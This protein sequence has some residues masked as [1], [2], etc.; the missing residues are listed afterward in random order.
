MLRTPLCE[1]LG[2]ETPV[3]QA[4]IAPFT[5]PEL[6]AAVC[7]AGGLGSVTTAM[8]PLEAIQQQIERTRGLTDR[9][10]AINFTLATMDHE[11]FE[12]ALAARPA[13]I[14]LALGDPGELVER[15]HDAGILVMH[16]VHTARQAREAVARG[17]DV[18]IAQGTEAGGFTGSVSAMALIP[19]VVDAAGTVPVVAA[20][21][22][23]DGR[24][25][26][27]ALV[28]GAQGVN[29]GTRCLAAAEAACSESWK[30]AL[31]AAESED[32]VKVQEWYDVFPRPTGAL[33][34]TCPRS[35]R[36][37]FLDHWQRHPDAARREADRV[38]NE[39]LGGLRRGTMHEFIPFSG[40]TAGMIHEVLPAAEIVRRLVAEAERALTRPVAAWPTGSDV[41]CRSE[42]QAQGR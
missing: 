29:I 22:I 5:S 15:I 38:Q 23:A 25:L 33:Y 27:A 11:A 13:V 6:V 39:I 10:F 26:A 1:L 8:Q 21:G 30:A 7:N 35:L 37:P 19:Q 9:P 32:A 3:I 41:L 12:L 14:S 20:G 34:D 24:G 18:I 36:T 42:S 40:Q 16:Q 2:I 31:V 17:V 4:A 28:L